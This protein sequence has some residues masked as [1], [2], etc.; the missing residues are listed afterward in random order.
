MISTIM[1]NE[2]LTS[3]FLADDSPSPPSLALMKKT[4]MKRNGK[5]PVT[6]TDHIPKKEL[7]H[8]G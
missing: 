1:M 3:V 8:T 2:I 4:H 6:Y 7:N 5:E